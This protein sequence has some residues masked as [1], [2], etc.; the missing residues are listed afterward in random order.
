MKYL[1]SCLAHG[2]ICLRMDMDSNQF[3]IYLEEDLINNRFDDISPISQRQ[4]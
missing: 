4:D 1:M 3:N 2:E